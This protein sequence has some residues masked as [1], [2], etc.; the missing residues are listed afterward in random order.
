MCLDV[1]NS[2]TA[3]GTSVVQGDCWPPGYN[4]QWKLVPR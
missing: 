3:H 1:A 2:S 4:Q